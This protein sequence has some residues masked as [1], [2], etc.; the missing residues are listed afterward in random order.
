MAGI[1]KVSEINAEY[2]ARY[3]RLDEPDQDQLDELETMLASAIGFV[4]SFTGLSTTQPQKPVL[5]DNGDPV[6]DEDELP[7]YEDDTD[8]VWLDSKPEF[9]M[10]VVVL[11]QNQYDNRTFYT[12]KGKVEEVINSTLGMHRVNLL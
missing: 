10:A 12:D 1:T 3:M 2:L 4:A 11:V 5:D 8:A 6:L 9:V 7:T